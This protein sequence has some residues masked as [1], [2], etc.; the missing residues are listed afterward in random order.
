MSLRGYTTEEATERA[1][2]VIRKAAELRSE[3]IELLSDYLGDDGVDAYM[4]KLDGCFGKVEK[5]CYGLLNDVVFE[6]LSDEM[7]EKEK[8]ERAEREKRKGGDGDALL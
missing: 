4:D 2:S 8:A 3:F 5:A 6:K 7:V 1:V